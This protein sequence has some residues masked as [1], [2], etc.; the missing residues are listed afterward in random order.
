[1]PI[2]CLTS[3]ALGYAPRESGGQKSVEKDE[4]RLKLVEGKRETIEE[5]YI[6]A[7]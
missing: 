1:M 5:R 6:P 2:P 7:R 4:D 3:F